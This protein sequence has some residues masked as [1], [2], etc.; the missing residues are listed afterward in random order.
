MTTITDSSGKLV[1][2]MYTA[3]TN[4]PRNGSAGSYNIMGPTPRVQ[5]QKPMMQSETGVPLYHWVTDNKPGWGNTQEF[6][7]V[8]GAKYSVSQLIGDVRK[9]TIKKGGVGVATSRKSPDGNQTVD[10]AAGVDPLLII[11]MIYTWYLAMNE[12]EANSH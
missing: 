4:R 12:M 2:A 3:S 8:E 10:I 7:V 6:S 11:C 1:A 5:G 9:M